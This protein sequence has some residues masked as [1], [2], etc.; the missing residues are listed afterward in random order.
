M[1]WTSI[2]IPKDKKRSLGLRTKVDNAAMAA[3]G[4]LQALTG[5]R[6]MSAD[7]LASSIPLRLAL[8]LP[9]KVPPNPP[10]T[11]RSRA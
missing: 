5:V 8:Y 4:T 1:Q 10:H 9:Q 2:G 6:L 7:T 3:F 11:Q